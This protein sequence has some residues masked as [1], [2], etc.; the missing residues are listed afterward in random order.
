MLTG[1]KYDDLHADAMREFDEIQLAARDERMQCLEDRRFYSIAGGQWEGGLG[2]QFANK[3]RF[4]FNKSHLAIIRIVSEY[5]NNR[6]TVDFQPKDGTEE[7]K[8]ADICDGLFRADENSCSANEAYDNAF[9]EGVGGGFGAWRVRTQYEDEDD[10]ENDQQRCVIEPIY[11]ADSTV[12]FDNASRRQDKAD[13]KSCFVLTPYTPRAYTDEFDDSP[14]SWPRDITQSEFDWSTPDIVWVCELFKVVEK[15]ETVRY[16]V[17]IGGQEAR[18]TK[19]DMDADPSILDGLTATGFVLSR[20]KRTKRRA[21]MKYIL[22]GGGVLEDCGEISGKLIPIV[23]YFG[24]RWMVDGVERCMGHIRIAKDAQ[25]L[26]NMIMSWLAEMAARFDIEKPIL[27]PEQIAGHAHMWAQD[28]VERFP[29][30]LINP[31]TDE[32]GQRAPAGPVAYTRAPNI[33]PAMAALAQMATQALNDMLGAQQAGEQLQPNMSGKAVEL[34]QTRLDMQVFIYMSNLAKSMKRCGEIWLSM[35][36]AIV[37]EENRKMKTIG[38]D[39]KSSSVTMN[40]PG[41]DAEAGVDTVENNLTAASF[42]VVVDVGPSSS[43]RRAATVRGITGMMQMTQD[44][45]TLQVLTGLAMMNMEGE[46]LSD[47]REYFRAKMVKI[48]AVKPT[49][50]EAE[51][52]QQAQQGQQPDAQSQYLMAAAEKAAADASLAKA[53]TVRAITDAELK[54]AQTAKTLAD[55]DIAAQEQTLASAKSLQEMLTTRQ[56]TEQDGAPQAGQLGS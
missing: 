35:M 26:Y 17:G 51:Q 5:R 56:A 48:G 11:D 10:D 22:S 28:N 3:P 7:D 33:P 45:E 32:S 21:V 1:Q 25:R 24:K 34:I 13:A 37:V 4:E 42:E 27:T 46:G 8:L 36:K 23:P 52:I 31:V 9:E 39:G 30:L 6:I 53:N 54:R 16:F 49:D 19:T 50:E 15:R 2:D 29:Y 18:H 20:E 40:T 43:S 41:F 55:A 47:V 12:F 14:S 44:P 38:A